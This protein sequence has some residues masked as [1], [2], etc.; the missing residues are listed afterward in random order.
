MLVKSGE[1][2][3]VT[4]LMGL[5]FEFFSFMDACLI[6][7]MADVGDLFEF[8]FDLVSH[9]E[10]ILKITI[11]SSLLF[12]LLLFHTKQITKST[13]LCLFPQT[14]VWW[15]WRDESTLGVFTRLNERLIEDGLSCAELVED[16]TAMVTKFFVDVFVAN[17][18]GDV[19]LRTAESCALSKY[20]GNFTHY[21]SRKYSQQK[22]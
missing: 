9:K 22:V 12:N 5:S 8:A 20:F 15:L 19:V 18:D 4:N 10:F 11:F 17:L 14:K 21:Y 6:E 1:Q 13:L 7:V 3:V 2:V 16:W